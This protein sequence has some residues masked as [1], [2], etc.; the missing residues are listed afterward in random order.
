MLSHQNETVNL[1]KSTTLSFLASPIFILESSHSD[2]YRRI[3]KMLEAFNYRN[4]ISISLSFFSLFQFLKI[5][6]FRIIIFRF[7]FIEFPHNI[8]GA[9][10]LIY[11]HFIHYSFVSH[12]LS[13][14]SHKKA[15]EKV[16][17]KLP[18]AVRRAEGEVYP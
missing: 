8:L 5:N 9:L 17:E 16:H 12:F 4:R 11:F 13:S 15:H 14:L 10:S 6:H 2:Y 3:Q 7:P 1:I 18:R